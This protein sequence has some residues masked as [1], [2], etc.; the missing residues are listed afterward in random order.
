M[1][2]GWTVGSLGKR[3]ANGGDAKRGK[4]F[5]SRQSAMVVRQKDMIRRVIASKE[6]GFV[7]TVSAVYACDTTGSVTLLNTVAQGASVNQRVSKKIK[8]KGLQ[9]RGNLQASTAT[10]IAD[11]AWMIVYDKRPV[12]TLPAIADILV[13]IST[14][15]LN[16]DAN[17]GRFSILKRVDQVLIGNITT[18]ATG[19]EAVDQD[20]YLDLKMRDTVYKAATTGAIADIEQGALYLVTLGNQAAGTAAAS[21]SAA[22]RLRFYDA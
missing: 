16:N 5:A 10:T 8:L 7:D 14:N 12:G 11:C 2:I 20:G 9:V 3:K 15:A 21:L 19:L 1:K 22:F 4:F 6:T 17:S 13:S 18:P